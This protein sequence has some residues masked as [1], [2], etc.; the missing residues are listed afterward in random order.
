[1]EISKDHAI[2]S[3]IDRQSSMTENNTWTVEFFND[4]NSLWTENEY[5][6]FVNVM[7]ASGFVEEIEGE[8]LEVSVDETI[9]KINGIS[10]IS[11]YCIS[12]NYKNAKAEWLKEKILANDSIDDIFDSKLIMK[13]SS[14]VVL[15]EQP[16]DWNDSR[17]F[18]KFN[19]K[20]T[21]SDPKTNTKYIVN[22]AKYK[23]YNITNMYYSLKNSGILKTHQRY[24]FYIDISAI[25][26]E[27]I[28]PS[29]I[30][31][32]QAISLSHF[33][34]SKQQQQKVVDEYY[35]LVKDDIL[36][37]AYNKN[38]AKP[39]LLAPKPVTL[40]KVNLLSAEDYGVIS[41]L[42]SYTVTEKA[43]GER[44][45][46]YVNNDGR[47]YLINNA[48]H[49]LDTGL[50]GSKT[51]YN[52]LIDGEYI[53]CNKRKDVSN[54]GLYACFD[55]YYFGGKKL[56]SLPLIDDK[57]DH[58]YKYMQ[59]LNKHFKSTSK[60]AVDFIVK[61]HVYGKNILTEC[62]QI[63]S[64]HSK[65]LYDID[66]L[67]F[68]PMYLPVYSYYAN[69]PV[70]ITDNVKWD[71]VFKWKP[72]EQNTIDFLVKSSNTVMIDGVKYK[73]MLL[74]V[75]YNASQWENYTI[76]E[77][78]R[79]YYDREYRNAKKEQRTQYIPKLF[80]PTIYYSPG[81]EKALVKLSNN[82]ETRCDDGTKFEN[83]NI[84]EFKYVLDETLPV[85]MR[86][87]PI[88]LRE[89]KTRIFR[90]GELSKTAN[91][92]S[93]A[94]NIWRSIHNPVTESMITGNEPV[95]N[96]DVSENE[97]ERLL[98][99]DDVYYSRNIPREALLSYHM[100]QFHNHGIKRMLY[101]KPKNKRTLVELA[102]GEGG[103]MPRW[104]DNG[105]KFILGIDL[106]KNNI[107]G[108]RTGAYSRMINRRNQYFRRVQNEK[109]S[110]TD[111]V[112]VA[113]DCAKS[114]IN[115]VCSQSIN[116]K[117]SE[118]MLKLVFSKNKGGVQKHYAHVVGQTTNGF[119]V[120]SCM[121]S[122][123]YFFKSEESLE[124][125]LHNVSSLLKKGGQFICTFMDGQT[126][127]NALEEN[128]IV[129]GKELVS[130]NYHGAP[131]WAIIRRYNKDNPTPYSRKIDVFIESTNKFIPEYIV[132]FD[133]LLQKC[134]M[135]NLELEESEMFSETFNKIK[136][137]IPTD[138][139]VKDSLHKTILELD[140]ND[141][142]KKFS[143]FNRWCIFKKTA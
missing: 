128:D 49:V 38:V 81:I 33:L 35:S 43:D 37:R 116:D 107:Y 111:M 20:V 101:S 92:L 127:E 54:N 63:L 4:N 88:R 117:E 138:D 34:L 97:D 121:F 8:S 113:G 60:N 53:A 87:V 82:G 12:D 66:G 118:N 90:A 109:L 69:K 142:Q 77:A 65:Y 135:F 76:D 31:M 106:V 103:D 17:K 122:I 50:E 19:K 56:T 47:V 114:I 9:L 136:R 89:D 72:A 26:N 32:E 132:L 41:I 2:F 75:G 11:K 36:V 85:S 13:L 139:S 130:E 110:F 79:I 52:S 91:D 14:R 15:Q 102:C 95:F 23:D 62:K 108:P 126:I 55:I 25:N 51:I 123:H 141:V 70:Q 6:N 100:L 10:N 27:Y 71:R 30:K 83:D 18:F 137:D 40:E 21:Y 78:L 68:T 45:L 74:Y 112:F 104:I 58:R 124:G 7:N 44:L 24:D 86:W 115:G 143:F 98:E 61:K 46:M 22:I 125:F 134:K 105:Y 140:K 3:M 80:K 120:C 59:E 94:I 131:V 57:S 119:D 133:L 129:E 16:S 1:M 28:I 42:E 64:N 5:A 84:V 93:V 99:A 73:E 29:I 96:K 48:Y 67:I 39:P